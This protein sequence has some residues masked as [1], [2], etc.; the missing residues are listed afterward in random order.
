M[1]FIIFAGKHMHIYYVVCICPHFHM[2]SRYVCCL[3][4]DGLTDDDGGDLVPAGPVLVFD[5]TDESGV[6]GVVH[7]PHHQLVAAHHHR[8][9]Q[10]ARRPGERGS[11]G[12]TGRKKEGVMW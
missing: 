11:A 12:R 6:D 9:W 8:V 1:L 5:L 7:F 2:Y 10:S 4:F 3:Q